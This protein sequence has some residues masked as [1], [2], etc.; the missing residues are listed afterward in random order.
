MARHRQAIRRCQEMAGG[1]P[2]YM[3]MPSPQ[4]G[5]V[6]L[7]LPKLPNLLLPCDRRTRGKE[8]ETKERT[9]ERAKEYGPPSSP[10]EPWPP[11]SSWGPITATAGVLHPTLMSSR[12]SN[13]FSVALISHSRLTDGTLECLHPRSFPTLPHSVLI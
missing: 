8:I 13:K 2:F 11:S 7:E 12:N 4:P 9:K 6:M 10:Y 3:A 5:R 1:G